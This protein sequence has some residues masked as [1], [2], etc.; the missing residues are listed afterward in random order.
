MLLLERNK[1]SSKRFRMNSN[2][3]LFDALHAM[4]QSEPHNRLPYDSLRM[5][6]ILVNETTLVQRILNICIRRFKLTHIN[7]RTSEEM[8]VNHRF[9]LR[10]NVLIKHHTELSDILKNVLQAAK[11]EKVEMETSKTLQLVVCTLLTIV[12]N[13]LDER[14][15]EN[16]VWQRRMLSV[17]EPNITLT[18]WTILKVFYNVFCHLSTVR[19]FLNYESSVTEMPDEVYQA[20]L[21]LF[22]LTTID[23]EV[24]KDIIDKALN[25]SKVI[26]SAHGS[27]PQSDLKRKSSESSSSTKRAKTKAT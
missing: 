6:Q 1:I 17:K 15:E 4:F 25:D 20:F 16:K 24:D 2:S 9:S 13:L 11:V 5:F 19:E 18:D 21:K 27:P 10:D 8:P 3:L 26:V 7:P 12:L 14:L 22:E 23:G